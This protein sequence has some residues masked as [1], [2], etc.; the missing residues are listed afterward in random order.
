MRLGKFPH[1]CP[2][3]P[4]ARS[5]LQGSSTCKAFLSF[6]QRSQSGARQ[7]LVHC[8]GI[9]EKIAQKVGGRAGNR[10]EGKWQESNSR[11]N[12]RRSRRTCFHCQLQRLKRHCLTHPPTAQ[13]TFDFLFGVTPP[14]SDS[15]LD[16]L[17]PYV[18]MCP[19]DSMAGPLICQQ[20]P[21]Q[22]LLY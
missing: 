7:A 4:S 9:G 12:E 22:A 18:H 11:E 5:C 19:W 8:G 13:E 15:F 16:R 21:A 3:S 17:A 10:G 20:L 14:V 1:I 6:P 2:E